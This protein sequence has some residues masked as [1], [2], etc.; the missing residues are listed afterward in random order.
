MGV[1]KEIVSAAVVACPKVVYCC[2]GI[3]GAG[4]LCTYCCSTEGA[5]LLCTF[6]ELPITVVSVG[7]YS[8]AMATN[9]CCCGDTWVAVVRVTLSGLNT[10]IGLSSACGR[11]TKE[12][13]A[14]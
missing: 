4:L 8:I 11:S 9:C 13:K 6:G 7:L 2:C 12:S 14:C 1:A 3:E 5:G 10:E